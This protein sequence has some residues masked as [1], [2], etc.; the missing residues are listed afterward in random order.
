MMVLRFTITSG[1]IVEIEAVADQERLTQLDL[2][3]LND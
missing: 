2:A 1:K 3:V